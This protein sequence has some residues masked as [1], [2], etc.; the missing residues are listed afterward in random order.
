MKF[1]FL[2]IC[3]LLIVGC[4]NNIPKNI[5]EYSSISEILNDVY[6]EYNVT[7]LGVAIIRNHK[8]EDIRVIGVRKYGADVTV[9]VYDMWSICSTGKVFTEVL[10]ARL[11]EK[12]LLSW[13]T[14]V[15]EIFPELVNLIHPELQNITVNQLLDHTA[16]IAREERPK[17]GS[18]LN[19]KNKH[20][21]KSIFGD[22]MVIDRLQAVKNTLSHKPVYKPGTDGLYSNAGYVIAGAIVDR[23]TGKSYE[24]T[25][26]KEVFEPLGIRNYGFGIPCYSET[27][28]L[29]QPR[30]HNSFDSMLN[31]L[32]PFINWPTM[33]KLSVESTSINNTV[34]HVDT[35]AGLIYISLSDWSKFVIDQLN[36]LKGNG[37]LLSKDTYTFIHKNSIY[38][39]PNGIRVLRGTGST[40]FWFAEENIFPDDGDAVIYVTNDNSSQGRK[41]IEEL[42][43]RTRK[44]WPE[45]QVQ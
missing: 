25:V 19:C 9:S 10:I 13:D 26:A 35:S 42:M 7:A 33:L 24:D 20:N 28:D 12:N 16:G 39:L 3:T 45:L 27:S 32:M 41:A 43:R 5:D 8:A 15:S 30:G 36:G 31:Y 21:L 17:V 40:G 2:S 22:S 1:I 11:V 37:E 23:V 34:T 6:K 38:K 29:E 18:P 4:A 14:T 44:T